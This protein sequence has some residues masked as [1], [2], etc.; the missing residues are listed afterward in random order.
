METPTLIP[1]RRDSCTFYNMVFAAKER[2]SDWYVDL[3]KGGSDLV[4]A[5]TYVSHG[6]GHLRYPSN[7][8]AQ[9]NVFRFS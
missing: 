7:T 5:S 8:R 2:A 1:C 4:A 3:G 9:K 6:R